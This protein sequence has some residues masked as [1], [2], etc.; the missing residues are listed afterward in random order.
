M[1]FAEDGEDVDGVHPEYIKLVTGPSTVEQFCASQV[2]LDIH[3]H[4][5]TEDPEDQLPVGALGYSEFSGMGFVD[6]WMFCHL[7]Y[8]DETYAITGPWRKGRI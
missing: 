8:P 6:G 4:N 5:L 3:L 2:Q 7:Q 1:L